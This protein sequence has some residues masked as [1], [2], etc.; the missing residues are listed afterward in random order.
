[1][2]MLVNQRPDWGSAAWTALFTA[3]LPREFQVPPGSS[4]VHSGTSSTLSDCMA[5]YPSHSLGTAPV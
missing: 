3:A 5:E 4:T 1:L 2:E